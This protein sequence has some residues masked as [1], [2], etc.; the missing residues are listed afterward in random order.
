MGRKSTPTVI[1]P[2]I[3]K[4]IDTWKDFAE[5]NNIRLAPSNFT[6]VAFKAKVVLETEH[7]P[8]KQDRKICPCAECLTEIK[9]DGW[10]FCRVFVAQ[11]FEE[12]FKAHLRSLRNYK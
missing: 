1:T 12:R 6:D 9:K 2:E 3:Q 11:N 7:C 4:V 10:C 8:C 5:K